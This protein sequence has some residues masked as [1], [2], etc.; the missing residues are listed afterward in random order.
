MIDAIVSNFALGTIFA[1]D[2]G[3][4]NT[5]AH[6]STR[7]VLAT[8]IVETIRH[9]APMSVL[10]AFQKNEPLKERL[11]FF[12]HGFTSLFGF[13]H[14]SKFTGSSVRNSSN[15]LPNISP[16]GLHHRGSL[17]LPNSFFVIAWQVCVSLLRPRNHGSRFFAWPIY[18]LPHLFSFGAAPPSGM[19]FFSR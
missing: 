3:A 15:N 16:A 9:R 7:H 8:T 14:R 6:P 10:L 5:I 13:I 19:S 2:L 17:H 4:P 18:F 1:F 11:E 12:N